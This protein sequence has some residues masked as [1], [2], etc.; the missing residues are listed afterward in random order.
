MQKQVVTGTF[1][2]TGAAINVCLGFNPSYVEITNISDATD[3]S[4]L[5]WNKSMRGVSGVAFGVLDK[6]AAGVVRSG[7]SSAGISPYAGGDVVI[8]SK[9]NSRWQNA[10]GSD[11]SEVYV[12]GDYNVD[13]TSDAG[14]KTYG[15]SVIP[16]PADGA[17]LKTTKG[18][19]LGTNADMNTD[20]ER[21][22]FIAYR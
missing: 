17:K 1:V 14:Y 7:L 10:A 4:R 11:V 2:G 8:Y 16:N 20:G 22:V 19:T 18:F 9:A 15:D 5:I 3:R 6:T 12:A 13:D 21:L